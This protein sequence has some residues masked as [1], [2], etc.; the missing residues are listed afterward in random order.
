MDQLGADEMDVGVDRA[1]GDDAAF[2][3]MTSVGADHELDDPTS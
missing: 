1:S 3:A 2:A